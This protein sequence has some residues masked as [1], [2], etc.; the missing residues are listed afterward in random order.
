MDDAPRGCPFFNGSKVAAKAAYRPS[1]SVNKKF[2]EW[3][4]SISMASE[5]IL[6]HDYLQL[7]KVLNAQSMASAK[8]GHAS[9]DE[10]LFIVVHQGKIL[11]IIPFKRKYLIFF[12]YK[13]SYYKHMSFGLNK[14][15]L[16]LIQSL[17]SSENKFDYLI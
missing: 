11:T 3:Q 14:C 6:Y 4:T 5:Q 15:Y 8:Y 17:K 16:K 13:K 1:N 12:Y 10:H 2:P 9:H 7:D